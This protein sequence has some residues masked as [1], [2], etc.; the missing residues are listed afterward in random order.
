MMAT[1]PEDRNADERFEAFEDAATLTELGSFIAELKGLG[2]P[3]DARPRVKVNEDGEIM[4]IVCTVRR[5]P[6]INKSIE[7][8]RR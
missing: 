7:R 5:H 1:R 3:G 6:E 8:N 2:A 4:G